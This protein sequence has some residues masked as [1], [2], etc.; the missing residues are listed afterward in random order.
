ML[1]LVYR[2]FLCMQK[3]H[4]NQASNIKYESTSGSFSTLICLLLS[5]YYYYFALL[6]SLSLRAKTDQWIEISIN[7]SPLV[8]L[9]M[10]AETT[11]EI[12]SFRILKQT[13]LAFNILYVHLCLSD[14][15]L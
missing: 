5:V 4:P 12:I 7:I 13:F 15:L 11:G 10:Q 8:T 9:C 14:I 1:G 2:L 3:T 6:F